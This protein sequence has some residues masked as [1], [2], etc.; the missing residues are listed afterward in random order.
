MAGNL[1]GARYSTT[2][3]TLH[4]T[5]HR[6]R[7]IQTQT[8]QYLSFFIPVWKVIK[9]GECGRR[10][11]K[12]Y[13]VVRPGQ[14]ADIEGSTS[15]FSLQHTHTFMVIVCDMPRGLKCESRTEHISTVWPDH[16]IGLKE[17]GVTKESEKRQKVKRV[18]VHSKGLGLY[19][20]ADPSKAKQRAERC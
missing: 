6:V 9:K 3:S 4:Y 13:T 19:P 12:L 7:S 2:I 5:N 20:H 18:G 1:S 11:A 15:A 16:V 14:P 10:F 17:E 8:D